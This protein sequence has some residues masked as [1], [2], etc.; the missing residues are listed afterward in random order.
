MNY[1]I[2]SKYYPYF[3]F[4]AVAITLPIGIRIKKSYW[5]TASLTEK[6]LLLG[7]EEIH[8]SS[9]KNLGFFVWYF[10]YIFN[11]KFRLIEEAKAYS[12]NINYSI[13]NKI[14]KKEDL[15]NHYSKILASKTY[16]N[17]CTIEEAKKE[18]NKLVK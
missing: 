3:W 1:K 13:D 4:G 12:E 14:G 16:F 15:I 9:I 17:M 2:V 18:L 7:H 10:K 6:E 5:Q 8:L 11:K